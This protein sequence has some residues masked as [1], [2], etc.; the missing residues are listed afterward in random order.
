MQLGTPWWGSLCSGLCPLPTGH[1]C[2]CMCQRPSGLQGGCLEEVTPPC[3]GHPSM[4]ACASPPGCGWGQAR[5]RDLTLQTEPFVLVPT[6]PSP[7]LLTPR[8][9]SASQQRPIWGASAGR[10]PTSAAPSDVYR[11]QQSTFCL[12]CPVFLHLF[13]LAQ[14][15]GRPSAGHW[16]KQAPVAPSCPGSWILDE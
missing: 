9:P 8:H 10:T 14:D 4:E 5:C 11:G 16:V 1:F 12:Q 15:W 6:Q 3:W 2:P 13:T 7:H